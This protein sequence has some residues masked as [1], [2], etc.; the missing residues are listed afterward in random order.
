MESNWSPILSMI[1]DQ[2]LTLEKLICKANEQHILKETGL[3]V[4]ETKPTNRRSG[5]ERMEPETCR[6]RNNT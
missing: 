5:N 1:Q 3:K 4:D 2:F 6:L